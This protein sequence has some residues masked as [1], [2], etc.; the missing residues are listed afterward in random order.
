[1]KK[2]EG[3]LESAPF[4][5][6][7]GRLRVNRRD[8]RRE[9]VC[10]REG[11]NDFIRLFLWLIFM[12]S[13][14][15]WRFLWRIKA[16]NSKW[17]IRFL[18]WNVLQVFPSLSLLHKRYS[19]KGWLTWYLNFLILLVSLRLKGCSYSVTA[20]ISVSGRTL[21]RVLRPDENVWKAQSRWRSFGRFVLE[22]KRE[23]VTSTLDKVRSFMSA[24]ESAK[25]HH[26]AELAKMI[27]ASKQEGGP[28]LTGKL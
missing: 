8:C 17:A 27:N 10:Q 20:K 12:F 14:N 9:R 19:R 22:N 26:E 15:S 7:W 3:V 5:F 28:G 4:G 2:L 25:K 6:G 24:L 23:T 13:L 11:P 16:E 1:M 18:S 21:S